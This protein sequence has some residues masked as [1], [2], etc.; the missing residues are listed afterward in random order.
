MRSTNS[1]GA[2]GIFGM[3]SK[4]FWDVFDEFDLSKI[5][6]IKISFEV[7]FCGSF[8]GSS[9]WDWSW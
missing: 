1:G 9:G 3:N 8:L 7:S 6:L 4:E 5:E 2:E